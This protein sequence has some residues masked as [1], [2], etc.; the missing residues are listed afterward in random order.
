MEWEE[1]CPAI[2]QTF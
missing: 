2:N 1:Q